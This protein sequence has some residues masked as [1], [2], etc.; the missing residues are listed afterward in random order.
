MKHWLVP[1]PLPKIGD[2]GTER[3]ASGQRQ[4]EQGTGPG[5]NQPAWGLPPDM[6]KP[7]ADSA[8]EGGGGGGAKRPDASDSE[9]EGCAKW[10]DMKPEAVQS[11]RATLPSS[12]GPPKVKGLGQ[13]S[14]FAPSRDGPAS[15]TSGF[16]NSTVIGC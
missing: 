9:V 10:L 4:P 14:P 5:A 12:T 13:F 6:R 1:T 2:G 3:S 15:G 8:A 16:A 11:R 7:A